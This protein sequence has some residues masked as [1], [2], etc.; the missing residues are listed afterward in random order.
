MLRMCRDDIHTCAM[1][2]G[3]THCIRLQMMCL[4]VLCTIQLFTRKHLHTHL[5]VYIYI[6]THTHSAEDM[7]EIPQICIPYK[8]VNTTTGVLGGVLY[9]HH[10]TPCTRFAGN[11]HDTMMRGGD[12]DGRSRASCS[13]LCVTCFASRMCVC[14]F[15][16]VHKARC[17]THVAINV[18][19]THHIKQA[20]YVREVYPLEFGR[21]SPILVGCTRIPC[22]IYIAYAN[23]SVSVF[24]YFVITYCRLA[25]YLKIYL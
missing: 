19:Y 2:P 6:Y 10:R 25:I 23:R 4:C 18:T 15:C 9:S 11:S 14:V 12:G 21:F 20:E 24:L 13:V 1:R 16:V 5:N 3:L 22:T 7:C 17:Q 8:R